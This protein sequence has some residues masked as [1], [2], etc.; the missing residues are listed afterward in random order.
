MPAD[1]VTFPIADYLARIGLTRVELADLPVAERIR[2]VAG[3]QHRTIAFE[4]LDIHRGEKVSVDPAEM[5]A[6]LIG[7]Q[8]GGICYQLN[9]VLALAL[10]AL[11][12]PARL[13]GARVDA[14]AGPGPALG[15]MAVIVGD[16]QPYLVDVGFGGEAVSRPVDPADPDTLRIPAGSASYLL[17]PRDRPLAEFAG[18]ACWHSSAPESRFTGSVICTLPDGDGRTTLTGRIAPDRALD[19]RLIT[20]RDGARTEQ[21]VSAAAATEILGRD[22]GMPG[23]VAPTASRVVDHRNRHAVGNGSP[24]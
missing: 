11:G 6:R 7:A 8:R 19:Y 10:D 21:A 3:A 18:M 2:T 14:G 4:N 17:D 5:I 15:H 1:E 22:F 16:R 12:V 24:R 23:A 13:W 20:Q 9:G